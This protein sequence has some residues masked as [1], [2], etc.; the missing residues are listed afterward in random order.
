MVA[1]KPSFVALA[2]LLATAYA[3]PTDLAGLD[4]RDTVLASGSEVVV[5]TLPDWSLIFRASG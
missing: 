5:G 4:K 3:A 1:L 2:T